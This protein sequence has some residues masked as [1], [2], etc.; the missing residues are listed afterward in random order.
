MNRVIANKK[1]SVK[2]FLSVVIPVLFYVLFILFLIL[3]IKSLDFD[4]LKNINIAWEYILI[5]TGFGL[6]FRYWGVFIWIVLLR[7]LGAEDLGSKIRLTYVYAKSWLGRYIPTPA[8]WMMGKVYFA[9]KHGI[10]RNKL[11]VSSLL[12]G[13][14]QILVVTMLSF[15]MLIFDKR[16]DV[17]DAQFKLLM[18][19]V[20]CAGVVMMTPRVFNWTISTM[21]KV[22]KK[23]RFET[24][25]YVNK[26]IIL[27][28]ALLYVVG[29]LV[30]GLSLFFIAKSVY[31]TLGYDTLIFVMGVGNLAGAVSMLAVF[32]PS[33]IGVREGIQLVLL[34]LIMPREYA[35]VITIATRLWGIAVDLLFF[36]IS[37]LTLYF[38][39][40]K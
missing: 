26:R 3:Y 4:Q 8:A 33:G 21:Y 7:S 13:A 39:K 11:A 32:A 19:G 25:H 27:K 23:K 16:L 28:G 14:L 40:T 24:E 15:T 37:K 38:S 34:S 30:S 10:S 29:A 5:A 12:E 35:L 6:F 22:V 2:A 17:V 36:S 18:F 20:I 1:I 9:S 31:P